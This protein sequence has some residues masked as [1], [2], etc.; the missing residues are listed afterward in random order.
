MYAA[1]ELE[2]VKAVLESN[3]FKTCSF[4]EVYDSY[5]TWG[6]LISIGF[7]T[8][9]FMYWVVE[10]EVPPELQYRPAIFGP[11]KECPEFGLID[12][13]YDDSDLAEEDFYKFLQLLNIALD[14]LVAAGRAH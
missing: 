9:D 12:D 3:F 7:S 1:Q 14:A 8:C 4:D 13:C 10:G 2:E 5:D 11:D 6:S